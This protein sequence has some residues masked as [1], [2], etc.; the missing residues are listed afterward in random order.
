VWVVLVDCGRE[1][2]DLGLTPGRATGKLGIKPQFLRIQ[3]GVL[4]S[5]ERVKLSRDERGLLG[6]CRRALQAALESRARSLGLGAIRAREREGEEA[7]ASEADARRRAR[8]AYPGLI[9]IGLAWIGLGVA[10]AVFGG[11][12]QLFVLLPMGALEPHLVWNGEWWR[13]LTAPHLHSSV[14]HLGSNLVAGGILGLAIAGSLG[15]WRTLALFQV[16]ALAGSALALWISRATVVGAS[17]G[18]FGLLGALIVLAAREPG[19][20]PLRQRRGLWLTGLLWLGLNA[21]TSLAPGVSFAG[22]AGGLVAGAALSLSGALLAGLPPLDAPPG[23]V[24]R[25]KGGFA[26][27]ALGLALL[28][29]AG[30]ATCW[31]RYAPWHHR[32]PLEPETRRLKGSPIV[33]EVP[34]SFS[35]LARGG[36]SRYAPAVPGDPVRVEVVAARHGLPSEAALVAQREALERSWPEKGYTWM[37][38]PEITSLGPRRVVRAGILREI[39]KRHRCVVLVEAGWRVE[40]SVAPGPNLDE[41]WKRRIEAIL[42]SVRVETDAEPIRERGPGP[43]G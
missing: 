39:S 20:V 43:A 32:W 15:A 2:V 5:E 18:V 27:V 28:S 24:E 42:S 9:C 21:V 23:S 33:L 7:L 38:R 37:R 31:M 8:S 11:L 25:H 6:S 16:S 12:E 29:A 3:D 13:L 41:E 26:A 10:S 19:V 4:A 14:E 36:G 30:F 34:A 40:V 17:G 1:F 22:H 35:P